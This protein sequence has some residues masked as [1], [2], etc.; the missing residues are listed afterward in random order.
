MS[1]IEYCPPELWRRFAAM[2]YDTL[3][4][5]A[6][7]L[8]YGAL[9]TGF[10]GLIYGAPAMGERIHWGAAQPLILLGWLASI[11]G[12]FCYFWHN[13]GQ[14]LGMKTWRLR[15]TTAQLQ[16]PSYQ[17]CLLRCLL[18]PVSLLCLGAGYWWLYAHPERQT[19]HDSISGTRTWL[20]PKK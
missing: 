4:V 11:G 20:T 5:A 3:L 8:L 19:L 16:L 18:A 13:S 14:T 9:V 1:H 15:I 10:H 2:I 7:S 6:L 12:F 17:Q